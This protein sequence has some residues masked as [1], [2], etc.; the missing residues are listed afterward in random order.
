MKD[1][2]VVTVILKIVWFGYMN[3]VVGTELF[4]IHRLG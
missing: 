4:D 3:N 2:V 1:G